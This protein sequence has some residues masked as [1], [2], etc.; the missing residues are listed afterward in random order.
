M[1]KRKT[2]FREYL[3]SNE[4]RSF[5]FFS[6]VFVLV[7]I[8]IS[9]FFRDWDEYSHWGPFLKNI[10][11]TGRLHIF[12]DRNFVH[13]AYPQGIIVLYYFIGFWIPEYKEEVVYCVYAITIIAC[14][15]TLLPGINKDMSKLQKGLMSILSILLYFVFPYISPYATVYLDT[16]LGAYFGACLI[17]II[18]MDK[19]GRTTIMVL[20]INNFALLQ[21]KDIGIIFSLICMLVLLIRYLFVEKKKVLNV[22]LF[23]ICICFTV[24]SVW[25][26]VVLLLNNKMEDQF[27][28]IS[29]SKLLLDFGDYLKEGKNYFGDVL[30]AYISASF[31]RGIM[32]GNIPTIGVFGILST[33]SIVLCIKVSQILDKFVLGILPLCFM[34]Y[35]IAILL[36]YETAMS[37]D[38]A[39]AVNSY[40]RYISSF[41]IMWVMI[42]AYYCFS[43]VRNTKWIS[44]ILM[45][46]MICL[47]CVSV[48]K[49][50]G[51]RVK[52]NKEDTGRQV[53]DRVAES[54]NNYIGEEQRVWV[55]T[56]A[57]LIRYI[58]SYLLMP[59]VVDMNVPLGDEDG[60][61][62]DFEQIVKEEG[63][64][65]VMIWQCSKD[66][67]NVYNSVF[68]NTL[69][70]WGD[71]NKAA[72]YKYDY[73]SGKL[74]L[75]KVIG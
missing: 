52:V 41:L 9:P 36:V 16:L 61:N 1:H 40:E 65:Y 23:I 39:M 3:K 74:I 67:Y 31:S 69:N 26:K 13:Q 30:Y 25:W 51:L 58:Y 18:R 8:T 55:V 33:I 21:I 24:G 54:C 28:N 45:L 22:N 4:I 14:S 50:D 57:H 44:N 42:L 68:N 15:M 47:C 62:Y 70:S 12:S 59:N 53:M 27:S 48:I 72:L 38:E 35:Y 34:G 5:L 37:P 46:A 60:M 17:A 63:I 32:L 73:N 56:N 20:M 49:N 43:R 11:E 10:K 64:D 66:F 29:F 19:I 2:E 75:D 7:I 6:F 71:I